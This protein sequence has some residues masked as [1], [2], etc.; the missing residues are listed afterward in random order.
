LLHWRWKDLEIA[1]F[2]PNQ[3]IVDLI[4]SGLMG[5]RK[6]LQ[7][8]AEAHLPRS[9]QDQL[10]I[11]PKS[12]LNFHAYEAYSLLAAGSVD[13][14]GLSER[15]RW[16]VFDYVGV[17]LDLA[18]RL[19]SAGFRGVDEIDDHN[20][21]CLTKV[22]ANT[23]PCD[24]EAF[25]QKALWLISKGADIY[26]QKLSGSALHDIGHSVGSI[27]HRMKDEEHSSSNIISLS[28]PSKA[29]L[30]TV[31]S[32]IARDDCECACSLHGCSPLTALLSGLLPARTDHETSI[33]LIHLFADLLKVVLFPST[34]ESEPDES[35]KAHLS[36]GI[37]RFITF[38][39]LGIPHTC[40]HDYR[41]IEP[42]EIME[43]QDEHK[44]PLLDLET[45]LIQFLEELNVHGLEVQSYITGLWQT[46]MASFLSTSRPH[47]VEE[48][49][50]ILELGVILN[51]HET[52]EGKGSLS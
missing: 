39:T 24:L 50:Q 5:R 41:K 48:V 1:S 32:D 17:N 46:N 43:I 37:L 9:V 6:R 22:L 23:P 40:L 44:L 34:S 30:R 28:E 42:E 20:N 19:W 12:L 21:T 8:L 49:I 14:E 3:A 36:V 16:S 51:G 31:L 4:V 7:T 35:F 38:K 29:L 13:L 47:S 52:Q 15:R 26:H 10:R 11:E 45:L 33:K 2:H 27:L 18:D 25:L